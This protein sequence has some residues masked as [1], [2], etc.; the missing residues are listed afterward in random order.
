MQNLTTEM[1]NRAHYDEKEQE[2]RAK[3]QQI[4]V[5]PNFYLFDC[6]TSDIY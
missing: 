1:V 5:Q 3:D 6:K 2:C 4:Q